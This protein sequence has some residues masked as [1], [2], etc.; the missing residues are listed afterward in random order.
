MALRSLR[1]RL[2][3]D[4]QFGDPLSTAG[5]RTLAYLAS[6]VVALQ[7]EERES[8]V[9][10]LSLTGLQ[11]WQRLSEATGR[12]RGDVDLAL[13]YADIVGFSSMT[14]AAGDDVAT[15]LIR[16]VYASADAI[17]ER[18][19]GRIVRRMGDGAIAT[20]VSAQAATYAALE[21]QEVVD[22]LDVAGVRPRIRAGVHWGRP[23]RLGG[24]YVGVDI[25]IVA[26]VGEGARPGQVLVSSA[27]LNQLDPAFHDLR[28]GRRKRLRSPEVP[29]ALQVAVV[30]RGD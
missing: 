6:G 27:A 17:V 9:S 18:H 16:T 1:Q 2:P 5:E 20:F 12:G 10:E 3:G 24:E 19:G 23:R 8:L 22:Q 4:P 15:E 29:P 30:R 26:A 14:L 11:M 21:C 28:I 25:G 13:L 7:P